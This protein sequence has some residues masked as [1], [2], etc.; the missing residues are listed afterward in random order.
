MTFYKISTTLYLDK[1]TE[2]YR[3]IV[4]INKSPDGPLKKHV[5]SIPRNKLSPFEGDNYCSNK[6]SCYHVLYNFNGNKELLCVEEIVD[7]FNFLSLN[8]YTIDN[9]L[10]KIFNKNDKLNNND[11][12]ICMISY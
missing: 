2:C 8:G 5:K 3:T 4:I 11:N 6:P 7:L 9:S 12:F 1:F 10:S